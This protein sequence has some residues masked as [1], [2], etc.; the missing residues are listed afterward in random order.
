MDLKDRIDSFKFDYWHKWINDHTIEI[1]IR[2]MDGDKVLKWSEYF[3]MDFIDFRKLGSI[4]KSARIKAIKKLIE[5]WEEEPV[6]DFINFVQTPQITNKS[7]IKP[8]D[9]L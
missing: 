6:D 3:E 2:I 9:E 4:L 1:F 5:K 7:F 8:K